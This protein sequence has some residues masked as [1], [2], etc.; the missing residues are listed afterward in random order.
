MPIRAKLYINSTIG[1]GIALL[2]GLLLFDGR[3]PNLPHYL[4]NLLLACLG[5]TFKVKLPNLRGAMS[6]NFVF[7]L[8]GV[9]EMTAAETITLATAAAL[10]QCLWRS[11]KRPA[12]IQVLFN[13]SM[14]ISSVAICYAVSHALDTGRNAA[15]L[16]AVAACTYFVLNTGAVSLVL[17]LTGNQPFPKVWRQCYLWTFPYYLCG[18]AI[19][20]A[21]VI[22]SRSMGWQASLSILP[23]MCLIYSYYRLYLRESLKP[24]TS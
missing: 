23:L 7:I 20:C 14:L 10:I 1:I 19:A 8:M 22:C 2:A 4:T 6:M 12:L 21:V 9:A 11:R 24:A 17:S 15:V 13:V 18:A 3:F 16:L 5:S